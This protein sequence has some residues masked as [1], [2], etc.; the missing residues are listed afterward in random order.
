MGF[1][2][3]ARK[4]ASKLR[5]WRGPEYRHYSSHEGPLISGADPH[6]AAA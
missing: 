1:V 6:G 2:S 4:V 5:A 3:C